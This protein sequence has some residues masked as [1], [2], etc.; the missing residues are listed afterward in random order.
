MI[1]REGLC[2]EANGMLL[3]GE[4][5]LFQE[6]SLPEGHSKRQA[7]RNDADDIRWRQ[8]DLTG[9][10][11]R[12]AITMRFEVARALSEGKPAPLWAL[13]YTAAN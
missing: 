1:Y 10:D 9:E 6:C 13:D 2:R 7:H 12:R 3:S 8:P 5:P 11:L 4:F